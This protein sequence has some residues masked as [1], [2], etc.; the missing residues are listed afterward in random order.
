MW[1]DRSF[2][3]ATSR[4]KDTPLIMLTMTVGDPNT[5]PDEITN[6]PQF[7]RVPIYLSL[8][9]LS[10]KQVHLPTYSATALYKVY[11]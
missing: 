6:S 1:Q 7:P 4:M 3:Q 9:M 5:K 10:D 2:T 11:M 8:H